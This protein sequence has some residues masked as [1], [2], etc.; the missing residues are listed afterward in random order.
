MNMILHSHEDADIR[1]GD[2]I[3]SPQFL[4]GTALRAFDYAV[5]NPPF[6]VKSWSN[7]LEV[8]Y[9]RFELGRPPGK[10]GDYAFLLHVILSLSC[11]YMDIP[12]GAPSA[13]FR[14]RDPEPHAGS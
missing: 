11:P 8:E 7:G 14:S 6:S 5:M 4:D 9:G 10:N 1:K 12:R 3:T 13:A 2:A